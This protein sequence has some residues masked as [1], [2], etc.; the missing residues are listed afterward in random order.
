MEILLLIMV[1]RRSVLGFEEGTLRIQTCTQDH[2]DSRAEQDQERGGTNKEQYATSEKKSL[3][4][5][6]V[7]GD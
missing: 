7:Q 2:Y 1:T 4:M 5:M 3:S 6:A